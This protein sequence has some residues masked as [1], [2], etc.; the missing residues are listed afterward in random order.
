M[1]GQG[2]FGQVWL[3]RDVV[4]DRDVALKLLKP[5]IAADERRLGDFMK[6]ARATAKLNHPNI[7]TV[8]QVGRDETGVF[9]AMEYLEKGS[10]ADELR[11]GGALSWRDATLAV[12]DAAAGLAEAHAVGMVHRDVKPANLMRSGRGLVK[13]ADFGLVRSAMNDAE[14][15]RTQPGMIMGS[16]GYMSPEQ[17]RGEPVDHRSDIY[18]LACSYYQL[19][20][21]ALPFEGAEMTAVM[22]KHCYEPFPHAGGRVEGLP[23]GVLRILSRASQKAPADRYGSAAEMLADLESVL[24]TPEASHT[25]TGRTAAISPKPPAPVAPQSDRRG[26][27]AA[28]RGGSLAGNLTW[29]ALLLLVGVLSALLFRHFQAMDRQA[30]N[31]Q[32]LPSGSQSAV[33]ATVSPAPP[34]TPAL[35]TPAS[36]TVDL[37]HFIDPARDSCGAGQWQKRDNELISGDE[38]PMQIAI[39]YAPPE[40]YD[41]RIEFTR[42]GGNNCIEQG[43]CESGHQA[44]ALVGGLGL[45]LGFTNGGIL[46]LDVATGT[47]LMSYFGEQGAIGAIAFSPDGRLAATS[48]PAESNIIR[49]WKIPPKS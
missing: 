26:L 40:E 1:L 36:A 7:V 5:G 3:A 6:E 42:D 37:M 32:K 34:A 49:V 14:V 47:Q 48:H 16:P 27:P 4:L 13:V 18:S 22:Y 46:L 35:G 41:F 15:T 23:D 39:P 11:R 33:A 8:F 19:L 9:I 24:A 44:T 31:R 10:L 17:C 12:R 20:T 2:A 30:S 29:A 38:T 21:R 28:L 45:L 43:V 25:F